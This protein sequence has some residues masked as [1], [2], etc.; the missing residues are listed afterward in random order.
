M[1]RREE[2]CC[3][4]FQL[5]DAPVYTCITVDR[6]DRLEQTIKPTRWRFGVMLARWSLSAKLLHIDPG[7]HWDGRP[8]PYV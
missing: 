7:Y 1:W 2:G 4:Q 8:C 6:A 5:L 3:P